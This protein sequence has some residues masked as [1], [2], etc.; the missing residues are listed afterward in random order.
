MKKLRRAI[1]AI[2]RGL[3]SLILL[4]ALAVALLWWLSVRQLAAESEVIETSAGHFEIARTGD[5]ETEP[6]L[7]LH[8]SPGGYDQLLP[9]ARRLSN[10]GHHTVAVSRPGYLRTPLSVGSTPAEQ[11]DAMAGLV[12]ELDLAPSVVIAV[13]G[14]G[15]S[16]LQLALR[17]PDLVRGLVLICA[18]T[19]D[20]ENGQLD[21]SEIRDFGLGWDLGALAARWSPSLGLRLLGVSESEERQTLL[22]DDE[23]ASAVRYLFQSMGFNS[24]RTEGYRADMLADWSDLDVPL[25]DLRPPVLLLHGADDVNVPLEHSLNVASRAPHA[26]LRVLEGAGHA[27]FVLQRQWVD[28]QIDDFL[29]GS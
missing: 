23:T 9:L 22:A 8:G 4:A 28:E 6:I 15:P 11:A 7:L 18:V 10:R 24:R 1:T 19:S 16:A 26:K 27:F 5:P 21:P 29:D 17:H 20:L 2:L 13:S 3:L 12:R 25:E 14:G